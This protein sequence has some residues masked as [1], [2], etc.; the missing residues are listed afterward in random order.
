[1]YCSFKSKSKG[2]I[3]EKDKEKIEDYVKHYT[4]VFYRNIFFNNN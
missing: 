1:M 4:N 2:T 3:E